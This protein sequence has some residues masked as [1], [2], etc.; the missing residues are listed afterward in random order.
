MSSLAA[1]RY[2][3]YSM[4]QRWPRAMISLI[5]VVASTA[6]STPQTFL[7]PP[8][9][10]GLWFELTNHEPRNSTDNLSRPGDHLNCSIFIYH[11]NYRE[12][13]FESR[14]RLYDY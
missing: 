13:L 5:A 3:D 9:V 14:K 10:G 2:G 4:R 1:L 7:R 11:D 12:L 6:T 8:L